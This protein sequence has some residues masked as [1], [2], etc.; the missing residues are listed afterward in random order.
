MTRLTSVVVVIL[1]AAGFGAAPAAAQVGG[2]VKG[3][4]VRSSFL[5][6]NADEETQA[7]SGR[8][9]FTV[10]GFLFGPAAAPIAAQVEATFGR[11]G[12]RLQGVDARVDFEFW[13]VDV[14]GLVRGT[15]VRGPS[16]TTYVIGGVTTGFVT[17]AERVIR[18]SGQD[19]DRTDVKGDIRK[20]DV[21]LLIG[22]GVEIRRF[23]LEGR[24]AHGLT[25]LVTN[26]GASAGA[27]SLKNR[28]FEALVG[29][30]F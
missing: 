20:L 23:V 12:A 7:L 29:V 19:P 1:F 10:G 14:S 2:G 8:S 18:E 21:R 22:V 27:R 11:R 24:Y 4:F 6:S 3:G 13:Y 30:R 16:A 17:R 28:A 26:P 9:D 15:I 25:H 5:H